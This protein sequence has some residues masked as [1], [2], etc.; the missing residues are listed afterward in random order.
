MSRVDINNELRA[1][2]RASGSAS[3]QATLLSLDLLHQ[4]NLG[5]HP[6]TVY[7]KRLPSGSTVS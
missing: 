7:V 5:L 6:L 4:Y 2:E 3:I 1:K